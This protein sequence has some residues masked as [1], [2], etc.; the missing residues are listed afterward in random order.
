[1][2]KDLMIY[3]G[4]LR[5]WLYTN[6]NLYSSRSVDNKLLRIKTNG[7]GIISV[8]WGDTAVYLGKDTKQA[9]IEHNIIV[10]REKSNG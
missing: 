8:V 7:T 4:Q 6:F 9:I 1:M 5:E 3:E 10:K 2:V